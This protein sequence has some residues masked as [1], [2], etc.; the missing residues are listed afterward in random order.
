MAKPRDAEALMERAKD[1]FGESRFDD[2]AIYARAAIEAFRDQDDALGEARSR[3]WYGAAQ[4]QQSQYRQALETLGESI[5]QFTELERP[6]MTGQAQ[7]YMAIVYEELGDFEQAFVHY[8]QGLEAARALGDRVLEGRILANIGDAYAVQSEYD[9]ALPNLQAAVGV[10]EVAEDP[11]ILGWTLSSIGRIHLDRGELDEAGEWL[12]RALESAA[13]GQGM[14][15]EGEIFATMGNYLCQRGQY[16]EAQD[17]LRRALEIARKL[18]VRREIYRAHHGLSEIHELKG[19]LK[20]ALQ[21]FKNYQRIQAE[22]LD[23]VAKA[24]V[25]NL[26]AEMEL[27]RARLEQEMSHLRNV[28]LAQALEN[29]ERL[30]L[31]DPLTDCYN[32]RYLD[33]CLVKEFKRAQRHGSPLSLAMLDADQFKT[34]NDEYSHAVGDYVLMMLTE[35]MS[36]MI[37]SEDVLARF[38][39]EEFVLLLPGT[40]L[41]GAVN[42]CE[43]IRMAIEEYPWENTGEGMVMTMSFGVA[44]APEVEDSQELLALADKRLY[45][46]KAKGRN[47]VEPQPK[48]E[49]AS[50]DDEASPTS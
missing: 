41:E 44:S 30:S 28:E 46:A 33:R 9:S 36:S 23:E 26:S 7:N 49:Q 1:A 14:R 24:K 38:G 16:D 37:R 40:D 27:Q 39:G 20:L 5:R 42:A 17:Y 2:A 4:T 43:K 50:T 6:E 32:R 10:L 8:G 25:R 45:M 19:D 18:G 13:K 34:I 21:E 3:S 35:I 47:R 48:P 15:C 12:E 11:S 29:V 22:V 31:V